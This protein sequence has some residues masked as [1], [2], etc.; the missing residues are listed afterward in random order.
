[1]R[2]SLAA[3]VA[4][5]V[6]CLAPETPQ[7]A[8]AAA[9]A[10]PLQGRV[11]ASADGLDILSGPR[12]VEVENRILKERLE[13]LL[14]KLMAETGLDMWLVINREYAEDP[15]YLTL[16][17]Q[18]S[19]AARRTTMLVFFRKADGTVE[20]LSVNRYPLGGPYT[21]AWAGGDLDAQWKALGEVI[22]SRD[23]K[24][25]GINVSRDWPVADGLTSALHE[26]LRSVLPAGYA[27][28]LTP[29]EPLVIRWLET[30]TP[31]EA[32]V[33][34]QVVALARGVIG[35]AFS[36]RVIRLRSR[37]KAMSGTAGEV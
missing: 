37:P 9:P 11:I 32:E 30:R 24:R 6:L 20:R 26:R 14:P 18:P 10:A 33:W 35:E 12:R 28:R 31:A 13:G 23:P 5:A 19:F 15:V 2:L 25:I 16:V 27:Q 29:A 36:E 3:L 8:P 21:S 34:P 4:L 17:P 7:A 22:A 1:M